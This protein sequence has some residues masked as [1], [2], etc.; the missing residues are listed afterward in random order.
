MRLSALYSSEPPLY[1]FTRAGNTWP[2]SCRSCPWKI[3]HKTR[4]YTV[5]CIYAREKKTKKTGT[6]KHED[7]HRCVT[8]GGKRSSFIQSRSRICRFRQ[9]TLTCFGSSG[10]RDLTSLATCGLAVLARPRLEV[11]EHEHFNG[12]SPMAFAWNRVKA[13]GNAL[14]AFGNI[15]H[16][17]RTKQRFFTRTTE[18]L[19]PISDAI[20][21]LWG[22]GKLIIINNNKKLVKPPLQSQTYSGFYNGGGL[23]GQVQQFSK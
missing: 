12:Q 18:T 8:F 19:L 9:T 22:R 14:Y 2:W 20:T 16:V 3:S 11:R 10:S 1:T 13:V 5:N 15:S 7:T 4:R 6:S 23:K 17:R 21:K